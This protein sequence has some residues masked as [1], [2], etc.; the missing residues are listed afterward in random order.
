MQHFEVIAC[1]GIARRGLL[2]TRHGTV[3]TPAF[4]PVATHG[5]V[6]A[7][8]PSSVRKTG[9]EMILSNAYHLMLR[10]G[11][12][13]IFR[14]GGL[15]RFMNWHGPV[16]TDSGGFQSLSLA[17]L[18]SLDERGI[19]FRSHLDGSKHLLTPED[20]IKTQLLLGADVIMCLDECP[21][22]LLSLAEI[23]SSMLRST[24]WAGRCH[25][26]FNS[27]A[28]HQPIEPSQPAERRLFGIVQGGTYPELR[29][30]SAQMLKD[31][32][33]DGYA[34]G[35]LAVGEGQSLLFQTLEVTI[36]ELPWH[37]PR[38]L[39]GVGRP[40]DI[41]GAVK[42]GVDLFDCVLPTRSGRT[43]RAYTLNGV[44]NLR[45]TRHAGDPAP[46]DENCTCLACQRFSR[47]YLHHLFAASEILGCMLLTWHNV[48]TYQVIMQ[49]LRKA[50]E[51][52]RL[53][54]CL[55]G[56]DES[57]TPA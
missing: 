18:C 4:M 30:R 43:G 11:A 47:A 36:P 14:L 13:R 21:S 26:S 55:A 27:L 8:S 5:S 54:E 42:R 33:F 31:I 51:Q 50:I 29:I 44:L 20:S 7:M 25:R 49:Q 57:K 38:Y 41:V 6:K 46:I 15:Q 23:E 35:G 10:P 52:D 32:G 12:E 19:A 2:R 34:I 3:N 1:A 24:R 45:N 39:M 53:K 48:H 16:L 28:S 17:K 22:H 37:Q 40:S 56:L 9:T